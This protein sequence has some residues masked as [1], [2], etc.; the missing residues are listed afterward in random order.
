MVRTR[1]PRDGLRVR[2]IHRTLRTTRGSVADH[3]TDAPRRQTRTGWQV[4]PGARH[5]HLT[6]VAHRHPD[7]ARRRRREED[8]RPRCPVRPA[9]QHHRGGRR[10]ASQARGTREAM[11]GSRPRPID[12][13]DQF[14]G[15]CHSRPRWRQGPRPGGR[16][17]ES[18]G[19]RP[20]H[21]D[22]RGMAAGEQQVLRRCARRGRG[23]DQGARDRRRSGRRHHQHGHQRSRPPEWWNWPE[24]RC[25][26]CSPRTEAG[27]P[28]YS[29]GRRQGSSRLRRSGSSWD[30]GTSVW[31]TSD[32]CG[33]VQPGSPV[34]G[35]CAEP[36]SPI[37]C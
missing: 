30:W 32:C 8:V 2:H 29:P 33:V 15:L 34:C 20:R 7:H 24:R 11:R 19:D 18:Q 1:T 36:S 31:G 16:S 35:C 17:V 22:R 37:R 21:R 12:N 27:P 23:T 13:P 3:R 4:V 26:R 25:P 14:P 10:V 9:P 28:G 6:A 5:P